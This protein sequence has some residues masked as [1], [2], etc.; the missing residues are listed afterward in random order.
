MKSGK[1]VIRMLSTVFA[2]LLILSAFLVS[3]SK[4]SNI[5]SDK[6]ISADKSKLISAAD[7]K[8]PDDK[9]PARAEYVDKNEIAASGAKILT[10]VS[11]TD[12]IKTLSVNNEEKPFEYARTEEAIGVQRHN[13]DIYV[14]SDGGAEIDVDAVT[15]R[16]LS[17][18]VK[19]II[20]ENNSRQIN[21][22]EAK[23][24]AEDFIESHGGMGD[25]SF[26]ECKYND[27]FKSYKFFYTRYV[28]GYKTS[29]NMT[30]EISDGGKVLSYI[31]NPYVFDGV[32]TDKLLIDEK[33][34]NKNILSEVEKNLGK[35]VDYKIIEKRLETE[36]GKIVMGVTVEYGDGNENYG[37]ITVPFD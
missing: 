14:T 23:G 10:D 6:I 9:T 7:V 12:K 31:C 21:E 37:K 33:K 36:N 26:V 27:T 19:D 24:I 20:S 32:D 25:F 28:G 34:L 2:A 29:E 15:G 22:S 17:Y 4:N 5:A 1:N 11:K 13:R 35:N 8:L 30:V 16:L 18:S 3:A